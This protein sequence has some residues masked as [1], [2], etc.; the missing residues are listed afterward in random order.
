MNYTLLL[1]VVLT[2]LLNGA[3]AAAQQVDVSRLPYS[4]R[5]LL[6]NLL[7]LAH[8]KSSDGQKDRPDDAPPPPPG[9]SGVW[10]TLRPAIVTPAAILSFCELS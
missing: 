1:S 10:S 5:I 4:L 8:P 9:P 7:R 2:C 6:E 3:P